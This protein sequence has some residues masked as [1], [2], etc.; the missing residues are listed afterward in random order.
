MVTWLVKAKTLAASGLFPSAD[1]LNS[2]T[3]MLTCP[4][5]VGVLFTFSEDRPRELPT[6]VCWTRT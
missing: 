2:D 1:R 5:M 6:M 4:L 3:E